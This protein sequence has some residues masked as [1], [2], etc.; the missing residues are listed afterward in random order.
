MWSMVIATMTMAASLGAQTITDKQYREALGH[1]RAG[2]NAL[3]SEHYDKAETEFVAATRLD[4]QFDAAFYGLGQV[5]MRTH[6][7][8]KAVR[9]YVDCREAFKRNVAD[10]A[11][12][13][14]DADRRLQ[15]QIKVL[16]DTV[17]NL[18][19]VSQAS[20]SVNVSTSIIRLNDQINLL[21]SRRTRSIVGTTAPV[22]A[23][24]SMA[25][26][27]AYLRLG[28]HTDAEREYKAAL[29]VDPKFGE[30]HSNLAV[31]YLM[32]GRYEQAE[33]EVQAAEKAGF[34]VNPNLK[35]DIRKRKA[36]VR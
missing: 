4:P 28:Q 29:A 18:E 5:Y 13:S 7:Y 17:R 9:A 21:E 20:T 8:Q 24:V 10:E 6:V 23:G 31:V 16:R 22:P 12:G 3:E 14:V 32:S 2:M 34:R 1:F 36:P 15:D 26:G 33:E 19:R 35:D 25:L 11:M 30:A 27:S